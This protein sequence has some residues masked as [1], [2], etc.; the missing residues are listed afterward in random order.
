VRTVEPG[1]WYIP[2]ENCET[3]RVVYT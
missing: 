3:K 1:G 2:S